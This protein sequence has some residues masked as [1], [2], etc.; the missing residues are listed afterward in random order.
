[1]RWDLARGIQLPLRLKLYRMLYPN[2]AELP[3]YD[4]GLIAEE[5]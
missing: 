4:V 1:M 5:S 2:F 3:F